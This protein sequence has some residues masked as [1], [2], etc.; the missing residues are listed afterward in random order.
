MSLD[1]EEMLTAKKIGL[2][3]KELFMLYVL[4]VLDQRIESGSELFLKWS[5]SY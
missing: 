2:I 1:H 3:H 5:K 4:Q